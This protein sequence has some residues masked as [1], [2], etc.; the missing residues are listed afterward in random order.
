MDTSGGGFVYQL[1]IFLK[2]RPAALLQENH[3]GLRR[4][5]SVLEANSNS[6]TAPTQTELDRSVMDCVRTQP[7]C[8]HKN[9]SGPLIEIETTARRP[10]SNKIKIENPTPSPSGSFAQDA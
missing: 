5:A 7:G 9:H 10:A 4:E 1:N 2:L 8:P 6:K 3:D